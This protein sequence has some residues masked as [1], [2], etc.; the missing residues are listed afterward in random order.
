METF[1]FS[2]LSGR[3]SI[4]LVNLKDFFFFE[5]EGISWEMQ[6]TYLHTMKYLR[7]GSILRSLEFAWDFVIEVSFKVHVIKD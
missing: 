1:G 7:D 2:I 5:Y 4:V 6:L 3:S